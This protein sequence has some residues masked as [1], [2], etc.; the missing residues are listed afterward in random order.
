MHAL[1]KKLLRPGVVIPFVMSVSLLAIL[2][3][4]GN[5]VKVVG[6][7]MRFQHLY[8]LY[9]LLLLTLMEGLRA[10]QWCILLDALDAKVPR[11]AQIFAFLAGEVTKYAPLGNYF[12]NYLLQRTDGLDFG[13]SSAATTMMVLIQVAVSLAGLVML[14]IGSWWWLRPLIVIGLIASGLAIW[15]LYHAH[16]APQ[17][18]T[19][20]KNRTWMRKALTELHN[21]RVGTAAELIHPRT[22]TY[23]MALGAAYVVVG[24]VVLYYVIQGLGIGSVTFW[25]A[26]AAYYFSLAFALIFPLPVDFGTLE[27]SAVGALLAVGLDASVAVSVVFADRIILMGAALAIVLVSLIPLRD[28]ALLALRGKRPTLL[29]PGLPVREPSQT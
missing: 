23:A 19:W 4:F 6:L 24:G 22:M 8:L 17:P 7:L 29:Q 5:P 9:L 20:M 1:Q 26:Q 13:L 28:E 3:A 10:A 25:G 16:L 12:P 18:P 21:F 11:R 14:G 15:A 27:I 2:L